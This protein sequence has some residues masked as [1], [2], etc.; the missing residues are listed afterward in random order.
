MATQR[1]AYLYAIS[2]VL[3]WSTVAA[4]FK[5]ALRGLEPIQLLF[6]ACLTSTAALFAIVS[7]EGNV[8]LLFRQSRSSWFSQS[9]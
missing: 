8:G 1:T 2:A 9:G 7:A 3:C 5:V 6:W 4:A